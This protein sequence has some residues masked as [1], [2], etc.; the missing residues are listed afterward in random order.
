[1]STAGTRHELAHY[2]L[3]DGTARVL[4]A[5]RIN[6]RV[7][8]SDLPTSDE[9]RVYLIERHIESTAAMEGLVAAYLEDSTRRGEPAAL[10]PPGLDFGDAGD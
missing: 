4:I 3:P 7:A 8:I 1:V 5:Q 9:G 10:V 6:G 2:E